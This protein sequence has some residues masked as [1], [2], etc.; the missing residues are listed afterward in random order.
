MY[1]NWPQFKVYFRVRCRITISCWHEF[2]KYTYM[3]KLFAIL[4]LLAGCQPKDSDRYTNIEEKQI[5]LLE[6]GEGRPAVVF[7]AGFGTDLT[8][9]SVV[10][11]G[12]SEFTQT[13]SYDR[14]GLGRSELIDTDRNL[15]NIT[16][17]LHTL[18]QQ[19]NIAAPYI[20]VGHSYGGHMVRYFAHVYPE[21]TAGLILVDP[22]PEWQ[23]QEIKKHLSDREKFQFDS[24]RKQWK[25]GN[26]L[27]TP[28]QQ[29]ESDHFQASQEIMQQ[30]KMPDNIPVTV[31]TATNM[32]PSQFAF[33][34]G[35]TDAK[36]YLHKQW[37]QDAP[38]IRHIITNKSGHY[39]H[40]D[41]PELVI[42]EIRAMVEVLK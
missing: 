28:G 5:H 18:L 39:V 32:P 37:L 3:R 22:T 17:E 15:A 14:A 7:V 25:A 33:L 30:L 4:V 1:L 38:Q 12:V 20:L 34:R 27:W 31:L 13:L 21:E 29:R 6:L 10:Q 2:L 23:D 24:L 9:F 41:E 35:A 16:K 19:E 36:V 26:E 8:T 42:R 11:K 40:V